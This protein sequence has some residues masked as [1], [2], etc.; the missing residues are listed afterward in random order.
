MS[1]APVIA[2]LIAA[3]LSGDAL[4]AAVARIEAAQAPVIDVQ[5]ERRRAADRERKR[6]RKSAESAEVENKKEIPPTPPKEKTTS[7]S[8]EIENYQ[9]RGDDFERFWRA[10]PRR[11]GSNPK[12]PA[13]KAYAVA[14]KRGADPQQIISGALDY[15][16]YR[17]DDDPK[18]TKQAVTWLNQKGWADDYSGQR[19]SA[20]AGPATK[21]DAVFSELAEH[22]RGFTREPSSPTPIEHAAGNTTRIAEPV[23]GNIVV[24]PVQRDGEWSNPALRSLVAGAARRA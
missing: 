19:P 24:G 18:F 14:I 1:L 9:A 4:V 3:G 2:E 8:N 12:D 22:I 13:R 7:I 15:A 11:I 10:Y 21:P 20:R 6:L 5:A 16:A 17:S 23:G